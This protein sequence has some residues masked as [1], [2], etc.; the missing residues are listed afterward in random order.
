MKTPAL[1]LTLV[2]ASLLRADDR[3]ID[4]DKLPPPAMGKMDFFKD[5]QPIFERSCLRCHNSNKRGLG[6]AFKIGLRLDVNREATLEE[7]PDVIVPGKSAKSRLIHAVAGI[8]ITILMPPKFPK[9][10]LSVEEV[11]KLR[12]WIDQ[13]AVWPERHSYPDGFRLVNALFTDVFP[14]DGG[15][16]AWAAA[17]A[18]ENQK[19][20]LVRLLVT[21]K[22]AK[23]LLGRDYQDRPE[24]R[25]RPFIPF[26]ASKVR[27][28][29]PDLVNARVEAY[30]RTGLEETDWKRVWVHAENASS[31]LSPEI[32]VNYSAFGSLEVRVTSTGEGPAGVSN[33]LVLTP[34][35]AARK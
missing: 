16:K 11:G 1:L 26:R 7:F 21:G 31:L 22:R 14:E 5:I 20:R 34:T 29:V 17:V 35:G 27:V 32:E 28:F 25:M 2:S 19:G 9:A 6:G 3:K 24:F 8:D 23:M 15:E 13:G 12:A 33:I 4:T 18:K 30:V 10:R